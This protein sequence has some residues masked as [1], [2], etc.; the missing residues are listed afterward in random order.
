MHRRGKLFIG[1][2][3][4]ALLVAVGCT[5]RAAPTLPETPSAPSLSRSGQDGGHYRVKARGRKHRL[6]NRLSATER[7]GAKGGTI[8]LRGAGLRMEIPKGALPLTR[9]QRYIDITVT[10]VSGS[11][12]AYEFEPHG[13]VFRKPIRIVQDLRDS[14]LE[15]DEGLAESAR[16][17]YFEGT[18]SGDEAEA[19]EERP[20]EVDVRHKT[21]SFSVEHFSG[22]LV[23]VG[24]F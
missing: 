1:I 23:A 21:L 10:A 14:D 4:A 8:E 17:V 9:S 16:G 18:L 12:L 19:V 13:L 24:F 20:T 22:Y 11:G 2:F 7:I 15:D 3:T 6:S 5:E